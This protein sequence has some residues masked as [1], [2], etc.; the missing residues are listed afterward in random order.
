MKK[1]ISFIIVFLIAAL[2][3]YGIK[4][5]YDK[6]ADKVSK[7]LANNTTTSSNSKVIDSKENNNNNKYPVLPSSIVM[8]SKGESVDLSKLKG[9][10][11]IINVWATWCPPCIKEMPE[12][13]E[14]DK[15]LNDKDIM[16]I[17]LA[18]EEKSVV[19]KFLNKEKL[20]FKNVYYDKDMNFSLN[21]NI[22][23]IPTTIFVNKEG[24][25]FNGYVGALTKEKIKEILKG[26]E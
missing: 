26:N 7:D 2:A 9:K 5:F 12:L 3:F 22:Q 16:L 17:E 19:E 14:L 10:T 6:N 4:N 8:N 21:L 18:S 20:T 25:I 24:R 23:S 13:S 11:L 1:I 15:S